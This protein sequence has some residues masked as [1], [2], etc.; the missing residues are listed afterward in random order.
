MTD[1]GDWPALIGK[2]EGDGGRNYY[3]VPLDDYQIANLLGM[4]GREVGSHHHNGDWL[5]EVISV[6]GET[7]KRHNIRFGNNY[8]DPVDSD[9]VERLYNGESIETK[10]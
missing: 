1:N 5:Y 3:L 9:F 7:V 6:L 2:H 4:L 8:G 10:D